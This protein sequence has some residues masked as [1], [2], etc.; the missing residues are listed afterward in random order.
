MTKPVPRDRFDTAMRRHCFLAATALW[1]ERALPRELGVAVTIWMLWLAFALWGGAAAIDGQVRVALLGALVVISGGLLVRVARR[2]GVP[3]RAAC[4]ARLER[5][6]GLRRGILALADDTPAGGVDAFGEQLWQRALADARSMRPRLGH[7]EWRPDDATRH[8]LW[9]LLAIA[10]GL[11]LLIAKADAPARIAAALSPHPTSLDGVRLTAIVDPPDYTAAPERRIVISGGATRSVDILAG[12]R[13]TLRLSGIDGD[14]HLETPQGKRWPSN[15][16]LHVAVLRG[17]DYTIRI[18]HRRIATLDV[19]PA[20]DTAPQ[21]RFDGTPAQ[22]PTGALRIG[23]RLRDDHGAVALSLRLRRGNDVRDVDLDTRAPSG[24]GHVFADLTPHPLAGQT[25]DLTL[26]AI[27]GGGQSGESRAIR[28][29]LPERRFRHPVAREI[30]AVRKTLLAGGERLAAVRAIAGLAAQ[31]G[32]Y[33]DDAAVFAALR[34]AG[35]RLVHDRRASARDSV[36]ALLWDI[37]TDLDDG[38]ASRAMDDL[39]AA[40]ERLQREMG[41]GDDRALAAMAERLEASMSEYLR[42]QIEAALAEGGAAT[43]DGS[44]A[45]AVDLGF[46]DRMF[47]DLKDRLAAGDARGAA[48]ALANLRQLMETIRFGNAAPDPD[49]ARRAADAAAAVEAL[50]A[51]EQQQQALRDRSIAGMIADSFGDGETVRANTG[52]QA[53]LGSA[54]ARLKRRLRE[55]GVEPPPTLDAAV[56][57]MRD[58]ADALAR[59]RAGD[60]IRAQTR[61]LNALAQA[62]DAADAAAQRMAQAAGPGAMQP[63]ASGSGLDPLGRPGQ[64]FGEGAVRLPDQSEVRRIQA[65]RKI[66]EERASDPSRS[67]EERGYYLRLL[68]RF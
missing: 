58:A 9:P 31:T 30:I 19:M 3:S 14:W 32:R 64:G 36:A 48:A 21:I 6:A 63:G 27:D 65:I 50:R 40:I 54:T 42:R 34:S 45:V 59:G 68:K 25:V 1:L 29:T 8:G 52:E 60:A 33:D 16:V 28:I 23:Y 17:G 44:G 18:G 49:A 47:A 46:L 11:G 51:I 22:T 39:R 26:V 67:P 57:A 35:W 66:L 38:G 53:E 41:S 5:G 43:P 55:A 15:G 37:A 10:V 24:R 13:L 62:S 20:A 2:I 61:A 12:S 56:A 4:L 7:V